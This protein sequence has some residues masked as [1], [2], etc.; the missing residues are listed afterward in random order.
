MATLTFTINI[1]NEQLPRLVAALE[2][3][4]EEDY[5]PD[6][7]DLRQMVEDDLKRRLKRTVVVYERKIANDPSIDIT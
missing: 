4:W 6:N 2:S 3:Q 1:P 5:A 7:E